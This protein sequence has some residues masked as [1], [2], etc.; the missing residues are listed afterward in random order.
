MAMILTSAIVL[1]STLGTIGTNV[2]VSTISTTITSIII[3]LKTIAGCYVNHPT[4]T[5][6]LDNLNNYDFEF[7]TSILRHI[8]EEHK[9][10][11]SIDS[12]KESLLGVN[13][14]LSE[15]HIQ[16]AELEK[17]ILDHNK[18]YFTSWRTF[19]WNGNVKIFTNLNE[20]LDRRCNYLFDILKI[21]SNKKPSN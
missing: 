6:V 9:H 14:V 11:N 2:I 20:K 17:C 15:I 4:I 12:I 13:E 3:S 21:Y 19:E 1:S 7:K 10:L 16:V 5:N 18:K 8:I